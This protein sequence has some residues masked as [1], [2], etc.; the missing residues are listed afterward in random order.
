MVPQ[1]VMATL[2]LT[3]LT[4]GIMLSAFQKTLI[5]IFRSES[6]RVTLLRVSGLLLGSFSALALDL[7]R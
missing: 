6:S 1:R 5:V 3:W 4:P 7:L 2:K